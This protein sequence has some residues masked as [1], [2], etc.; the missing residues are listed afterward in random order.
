MW[1]GRDSAFLLQVIFSNRSVM[2]AGQIGREESKMH[3][4]LAGTL[5][6]LLSPPGLTAVPAGTLPS[7]RS[8][9]HQQQHGLTHTAVLCTDGLSWRQTGRNIPIALTAPRGHMLLTASRVAPWSPKANSLCQGR[10]CPALPRKHTGACC[11]S[12]P[13]TEGLAAA[14]S[15]P[16]KQEEKQPPGPL[17]S[18]LIRWQSG[19]EPWG[20]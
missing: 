1:G 10:D 16:H 7:E 2:P 3:R 12:C 4:L 8:R 6:H 11:L 19:W 14:G 5:S 17:S 20:V 18:S 13:S 15:Q 9:Q